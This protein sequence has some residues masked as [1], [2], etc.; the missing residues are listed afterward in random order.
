MAN[1]KGY[2]LAILAGILALISIVTPV[3]FRDDSNATIYVWMWT[4]FTIK[5][6]DGDTQTGWFDNST[7]QTWGF[8]STII[9]LLAM[10]ILFAS[11]AKAKGDNNPAAFILGGIMLIV[12]PLL[13]YFTFLDI[14][15]VASYHTTVLGYPVDLLRAMEFWDN[16]GFSVGFILPFVGG[17]I[18]II[19]AFV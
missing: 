19:G 5:I 17:G 3:A 9:I 7:L 6:G 8:V 1:N 18:A 11:G 16:M 13:L 10:V 15:F 2:I 14:D 12:A 4:L